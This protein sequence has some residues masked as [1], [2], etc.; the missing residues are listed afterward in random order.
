LK[1]IRLPHYT[2]KILFK[3]CAFPAIFNLIPH[4][5]PCKKKEE[6]QNADD[7][8][9]NNGIKTLLFQV[10]YSIESFDGTL[11]ATTTLLL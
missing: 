8:K 3:K 9:P 2:I 7:N 11:C 1:I 10:Y 6:N 4:T 5:N